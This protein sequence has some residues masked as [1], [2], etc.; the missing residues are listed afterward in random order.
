MTIE[1]LMQES[2]SLSYQDKGKLV[3]YLLAMRNREDPEYLAEI[4]G[5]IEDRDPNHWLTP[6]EFSKR[7]DQMD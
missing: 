7:L 6:E 4:Q 1:Q 5:R 2:E 3:A